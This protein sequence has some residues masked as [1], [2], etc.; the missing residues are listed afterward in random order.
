MAFVRKTFMSQL[1]K[2]SPERF[3]SSCRATQLTSA[4]AKVRL[5]AVPSYTHL[6]ATEGLQRP[7]LL[8][9]SH[10]SRV[11]KMIPA[12]IPGAS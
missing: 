2:H 4:K 1:K 7:G 5:Q 8:G 9:A 12:C 11:L 10:H 3:N 6:S